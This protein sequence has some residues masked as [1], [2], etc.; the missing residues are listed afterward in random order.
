MLEVPEGD[1]VKALLLALLLSGCVATVDDADAMLSCGAQYVGPYTLGPG[2]WLVTPH[3]SR[4]LSLNAESCPRD[5]GEPRL[6]HGGDVVHDWAHVLDSGSEP[7]RLT[8]V[9]CE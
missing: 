3:P 6:A 8:A 9:S 4:A 5:F 1:E 2:C 7:Y